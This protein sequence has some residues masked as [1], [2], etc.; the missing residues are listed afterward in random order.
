[1][2]KPDIKTRFVAS[3][4]RF[5]GAVKIESEICSEL[6]G[7]FNEKELLIIVF[8]GENKNVKMSDIADNLKAPLSTLTS[9]VDKLVEK[10][11]LAR[12]HSDED[13]RVVNV[14]LMSKGKTAFKTFQKR[15]DEMAERVLSQFMGGEQTAFMDY[16]D[17]MSA[18]IESMK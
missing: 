5:V 3:M 16:L 4:L 6:C 11:Y 12:V 14:T 9:I 1:M 13:R 15:K 17:K 10:Q 18:V 7:G 8:V 2:V